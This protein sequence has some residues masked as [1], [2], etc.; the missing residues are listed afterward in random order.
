MLALFEGTDST[1]VD[2]PT[3]APAE[4][5]PAVEAAP[6]T[7][8][9]AA[10]P[11]TTDALAAEDIGRLARIASD[12]YEAAQTA[13]RRGDWATYGRELGQMEAALEALVELT[14]EPSGE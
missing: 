14:G 11:T 2:A 5:E 3:E 10:G 9:P 12:H 4:A 6:T 8:A 13:L 1:L 7:G